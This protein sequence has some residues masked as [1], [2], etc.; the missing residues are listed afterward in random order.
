MQEWYDG[1]DRRFGG[2][3]FLNGLVIEESTLARAVADGGLY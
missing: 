3:W 2:K 1:G